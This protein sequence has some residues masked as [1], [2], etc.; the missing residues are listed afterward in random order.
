MPM[1]FAFAAAI[2][3]AVPL[4]VPPAS[5]CGVETD[6]MLESGRHY[7]IA[8]PEGQDSRPVGA[9]VYAH[10]Y[11]GSARGPMGSEALKGAAS[12]L[13]VALIALASDGDDWM[14]PGVPDQSLKGRPDDG[15]VELAY[16]EDVLADAS[17][18]HGID[19]SRLMATGFS[20]GGMM[21]W[22]LICHGSELFQGFAPIAGTFWKPEPETCD[23]P[24]ADVL[25]IHG[26]SDRIV[27]LEGR[28]IAETHQGSLT[29]VLEMYGAYGGFGTAEAA[30]LDGLACEIRRNGRGQRLAVCLHPGGH[31]LEARWLG[32]AWRHFE[33]G[34][35]L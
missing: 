6:C 12:E 10:G 26:T 20:A 27:P 14:I 4:L 25:H 35:G 22:T 15:G 29:E 3:A 5:A 19:R 17:A 1:R 11:K 9:I 24:P 21:I 31:A 2:L 18:R 8:L 7:R 32:L 13:G 16:I 23:S 33:A 34:G 28:P 30:D